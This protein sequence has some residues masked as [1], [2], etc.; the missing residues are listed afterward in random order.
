[1]CEQII[2]EYVLNLIIN[3]LPSK[4]QK[5]IMLLTINSVLNLIINGLPSK[6]NPTYSQKEAIRIQVLNLIINGLPS[7]PMLFTN[8]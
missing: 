8:A 3:G 7:K 5:D 2:E 6:R 1:M 4:H